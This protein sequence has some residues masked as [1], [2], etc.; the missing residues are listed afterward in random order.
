M[1]EA[2]RLNGDDIWPFG[3]A[4]DDGLVCNCF[5]GIAGQDGPKF[6]W[7]LGNLN[8]ESRPAVMALSVNR[9]IQPKITVPN[10]DPLS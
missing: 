1:A 10:V 6:E 8:T 7:V 9:K 5:V 2:S 4:S 3:L